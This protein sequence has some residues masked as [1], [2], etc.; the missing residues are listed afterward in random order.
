M[1][2]W[3]INELLA[4]KTPEQML[5]LIKAKVAEFAAYKPKLDSLTTLKDLLLLKEDIIKLTTQLGAYYGLQEAENTENTQVLAKISHL[6]QIETDL[7]NEML[8]FPIW[9]MHLPD[10]KAEKLIQNTP[11]YAYYLRTIILRKKHT[12]NENEEKI[13]SLKSTTDEAF[14]TLYR[15]ITTA[16][17]FKFK[18]KEIIQTELSPYVQSSNPKER[19]E[20]YKA[21]LAKYGENSNVLNELYKSIVINWRTEAIKIRNYGTS[22]GVRNLANDIDDKIIG[23]LL[24]TIRKNAGVFQEYFE[25]KHKING[26]KYP[27]NRYHIYAPYNV[28]QKKY[29]YET[30]LKIVLEMYKDFDRCFYD[31]A[32]QIIDAQHIHTHPAKNKRGGAFCYG[33]HNKMTP[34]IMLNHTGILRD[35]FTM[36][37]EFGHGI[38]DIFSMKQNNLHFRTSLPMAETAST[39][40]EMMLSNKLLNETKDKKIRISILLS[41]LDNQFASITRQAYFVVFEQKAHELIANGA[42]KEQLDTCYLELLKEQFGKMQVADE[43][44]HE[45]NYIPHIHE[46]PFYCYAYAWGCLMVLALYADYEKSGKK[47]VDK[48]IQLLSAGGSDSPARILAKAGFDVTKQEFWQK[49]FDVIK[50]EIEELRKLTS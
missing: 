47:F 17:R 21:I 20:A 25:L 42:T 26:G 50:E 43:F 18:G 9:F 34:Y 4:G 49:G 19:E 38:H 1:Q 10:E 30:S 37:H 29:D 13:I 3:K 48:Y 24:T 7:R 28:K 46:T 14:E 39:F 45:W 36:A 44:K 35:V 23:T 31:A 16:F 11:Q 22:I 6:S 40:G 2:T 8:F 15:L 5:D 33:I 32:K 27:N 12:L 41:Q